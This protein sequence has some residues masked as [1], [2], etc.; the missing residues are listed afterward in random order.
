MN[1]YEH[2]FALTMNVSI[3]VEASSYEEGLRLA[4]EKAENSDE[5]CAYV[6]GLGFVRFDVVEHV[7]CND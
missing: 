7:T 2:T 1:E 3:P 6:E 4:Q 5:F